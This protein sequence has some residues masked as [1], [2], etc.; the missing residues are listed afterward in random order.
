MEAGAVASIIIKDENAGGW[1]AGSLSEVAVSSW[2]GSQSAVTALPTVCHQALGGCV[3]SWAGSWCQQQLRCPWCMPAGGHPTYSR[4]HKMGSC[5]CWSRWGVHLLAYT[6]G[7]SVPH[8]VLKP[9]VC[10]GSVYRVCPA[11]GEVFTC[12]HVLWAALF[13]LSPSA[14]F[15]QPPGG[16]VLQQPGRSRGMGCRLCVAAGVG[17][18]CWL[19][20]FAVLVRVSPLP[21]LLHCVCVEVSTLTESWQISFLPPDKPQPRPPSHRSWKAA[22]QFRRFGL[23]GL[24]PHPPTLLPL[25]LAP[26]HPFPTAFWE[27]NPTNPPPLLLSLS[28]C[29]HLPCTFNHTGHRGG[30]GQGGAAEGGRGLAGHAPGQPAHLGCSRQPPGTAPRQS[31]QQPG[32][33]R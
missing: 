6:M 32:R 12:W 16:V 30:A 31:G 7:S 8:R 26:P 9:C 25:H 23:A 20:G 22:L 13:Q 28:H 1:V 15:S 21:R 19:Q 10:P 24:P 3:D 17:C 11:G 18:R 2:A 5:V 4:T 27:L 14:E 29:T 33:V